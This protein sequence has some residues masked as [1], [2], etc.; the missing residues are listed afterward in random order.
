MAT[1]N[2]I[3]YNNMDNDAQSVMHYMRH[4][5][6]KGSI[7]LV[8]LL[9]SLFLFVKTVGE[10][11]SYRFIGGGVPATNTITVSGVGE[12]FAVPDIGS[13]SFSVSEEKVTVKEAQAEATRKINVAL[14]LLRGANVEERDIKTTAY[15][16]YPQYT[17]IREICKPGFP[18]GGG[19]RELTGY[20]VS[21][22]ISV[23]IRD[24]DKAGEILAE[25]GSVGVTNVS[26]LNFTIDDEDELKRDARREA[27]DDARAKA[28]QLARDLGVKLIRVVSFSEGGGYP[29][30]ARSFDLAIESTVFG[31]GGLEAPEIPVGENKITSNVSITY[32]IR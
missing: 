27:I 31:A 28:K 10:I 20:N 23:K 14:G 9:L 13:F 6:I 24:I 7:I 29:V 3:I 21:Q 17:Y 5:K 30:Y 2:G 19:K 4:D 26:G 11:K 25:I 12:V 16:V 18:C 22:T 32:E 8:L 15:N 1:D